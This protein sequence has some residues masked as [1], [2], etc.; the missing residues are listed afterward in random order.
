MI[1]SKIIA[2][3]AAV[4]LSGAL[5]LSASAAFVFNTNLGFG[6]RNTDVTALQLRLNAETGS[7]LPGTTYYG[8]L[9]RAAVIAYQK[10]KGITP[11]VGFTG[12]ITR[13]ALNGSTGT[14]FAPGD[15]QSASGFDSLSGK[16]CYAI[17]GGSASFGPPDCTSAT[18]FSRLTGQACYAVGSGAPV[19]GSA[20]AG[21][22]TDTPVTSS[23]ADAGN[24]NFTK[25][26]VSAGA[27]NLSINSIRV[28]RYG[29]STNTSLENIK[30]LDGNGVP[31][32]TSGTLNSN[33]QVNLS[34][35]PAIVIPAG[36]TSQFFI[37]AG[38]LDGTAGGMTASLGIA[39][40]SDISATQTVSGSFPIM[41]NIVGSVAL[42]IGSVSVTNDGSVGDDTPDVGNADVVLN[43][44]KI[45]TG[46]T[47]AVTISQISVEK[48]GSAGSADVSNI[49][50]YDVTH[51]VSLGTVTSW[52]AQG[53]ATF[54][55]LNLA[56]AKGSDVRLKVMADVVNGSGLT[57]NA[58]L[59]DGSD[60]RVI[61]RGNDYG[62]FITPTITGSWN[63]QGSS[64][65]TI[66]SG[67]L[68]IAKSVSTPATGNVTKGNDRL[69]SVFDVIVNGEAVRITS[70]KVGFNLATMTDSEIS[71][72][73]LKNFTTGAVLGGPNSVSTTDYDPNTS[74][75]YEATA[76][77]TDTMEFPVGTTKVGL[78][79]DIASTV[80]GSDTIMAGLPDA[81]ADITAKG[82]I[83]NDTI[84]AAPS[85][86]EVNGNVLT[87]QA[88]SL[89]A[90]TLTSPV[91][92]QVVK[93]SQDY[94]W[95]EVS[96]SAANSGED[97]EVTA[98]VV[99]DTLGD[100]ADDSSTIDNM[101][102]W[103][104][105]TSANCSS[106]IA[107]CN[108]RTD[109]YETKISNTEQPDD[110]GATDETHSITLSQTL[111]ILKDGF[112]KIAIIA[113]LSASSTTGDT[114]AISLDT[115]AGDVTANG[116]TT[117]ATISVTPTGAGQVMTVDAGG[118]LTVSV[119]SS[120]PKARVVL[121]AGQAAT[122]PVLGTFRLAANSDE[123]LELDSFK[124]T[125]DGSDN[126]I[127]TYYFQAYN[128][129]GTT[130]LGPVVE[131]PGG[132]TATAYWS[133]GAVTIPKNSHILMKVSGK[134]ANVDS[135]AAANEGT[136]QV[137]VAADNTDVVT[138]GLASG[139]TINGGGS[140]N[141]DATTHFVFQSYPTFE[142]VTN[143]SAT[144]GTITGNTNQLLG[145]LKITAVGNEDVSFLSGST[146]EIR[147]QATYVG[148]D[149]DTASETLTFKDELGTTLDVST[150]ATTTADFN[151][152][153]ANS[154]SEFVVDF[155][156]TALT[157][158]AGGVKYIYVYGMTDD[159][160]D[161]GDSIQLWN[162]NT[163]A[164][165]LS[166]A[167]DGTGDFDAQADILWRSD[168]M[169]DSYSQLWVNPS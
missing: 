55:G 82:V 97:V 104:D 132:A 41:G 8:S 74:S 79:V 23:L 44:F 147:F 112:V 92:S 56:I 62:F 159:F 49:E 70:F 21:L 121:D 28:T 114:H 164:A 16:A 110:S 3:V 130:A 161:N 36:T 138:T 95:S 78:Y 20:I 57:L 67:A 144:V 32:T 6:M 86:A 102:I 10:A 141:Y 43:K 167:I 54:N 115:D 96:L 26:Y 63:G 150:D 160:E 68:T 51:S 38:Y 108:T 103:A 169:A 42:T 163:T 69:I 98:L 158:P 39:L 113:D 111:T 151:S 30:I 81:D 93:G 149:T 100:A 139:T 133:D 4:A 40:A 33:G 45:T 52:N 155:S 85:A 143:S 145:K 37:R 24:A 124:I 35:T 17:S 76:T 154:T 64:N 122:N 53:I 156:T 152:A 87:L 19:T 148:D 77:F 29:L 15:C 116:K 129:T 1:K 75:S 118:A 117:G 99:E 89:S 60:V 101:E 106:A 128:T 66:A 131:V 50:L 80:S 12:P 72:V 136:V 90:T 84:T 126:V 73:R 105:L 25:F 14:T 137:T 18:G 91:L 120:S 135:S 61:A 13:A 109:A 31:L 162:D 22:S 168:Y 146:S 83:S 153:T 140:T 7:T 142:W 59:T 65:Q 9:T 94:L 157:V 11:A 125:D 107:G 27:T 134:T 88:G 48:Q 46:S 119:D 165:D 166:W 34:F 5:A 58:D 2:F 127:E 71:N 47:E 123:S